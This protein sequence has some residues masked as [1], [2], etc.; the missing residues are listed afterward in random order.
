MD[1]CTNQDVQGDVQAL[2]ARIRQQIENDSLVERLASTAMSMLKQ[3]GAGETTRTSG[4]NRIDLVDINEQLD[5]L[6]PDARIPH[7]PVSFSILQ[8]TSHELPDTTLLVGIAVCPGSRGG[9]GLGPCE[10]GQ[11]L[12]VHQLKSSEPGLTRARKTLAIRCALRLRYG[13]KRPRPRTDCA[14]VIH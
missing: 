5:A 6:T 8:I 3:L 13:T 10:T 12:S 2:P 4:K 14:L 7:E 1:V 9:N 11:V